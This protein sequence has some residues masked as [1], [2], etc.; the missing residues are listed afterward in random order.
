MARGPSL[1][2]LRLDPDP[3]PSLGHDTLICLSL[4]L[5]I[6]NTNIAIES[7]SY[8]GWVEGL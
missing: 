4:L 1:I 8:S 3:G 7:K 5:S 6:Q 2:C